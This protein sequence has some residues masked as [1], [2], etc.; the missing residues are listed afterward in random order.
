MLERTIENAVL[1]YAKRK[2]DAVVVKMNL[3]GRRSWPDRMFFPP[4]G[5]PFFIEFK[6]EGTKPTALQDHTHQKLATLGYKVWVIDDISEGKYVI[7][8]MY[9][10]VTL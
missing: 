4:G 7:D 8:R 10:S 9:G 5:V 2:Y 6:R 3:Q 1:A